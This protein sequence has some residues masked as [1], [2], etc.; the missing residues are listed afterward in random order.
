MDRAY[1]RLSQRVQ[2]VARAC[3]R[4]MGGAA[5]YAPHL[6][7]RLA[8]AELG[9]ADAAVLRSEGYE[10]FAQMSAE[11]LRR[12]DG[13]VEDY[14]AWMRPWGFAPEELTVPVDIWVGTDDE[15]VNPEWSHTLARRIP[16]AQLNIRSGGHFVAHL[17]YPEIL[18]T[19]AGA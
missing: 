19:L 13:V 10:T 5:R 8:A 7:G 18:A 4:V 3:F 12:P 9:P 11:A 6:Y 14:R 2:P 17:H 1:T 15:L 16:L